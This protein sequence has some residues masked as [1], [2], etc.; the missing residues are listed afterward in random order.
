[1]SGYLGDSRLRHRI[2]FKRDTFMLCVYCGNIAETREHSP[3]KVFLSTPYPDNL[4]VVPACFDC[5]NGFS[6]DELYVSIVL[7]LLKNHFMP[8]HVLSSKILERLDNNEGVK[9]KRFVENYL[10]NPGSVLNNLTI[11]RI[12]H[13]LAICHATYEV[14]EG[15]YGSSWES[16]VQ[17]VKYNCNRQIARH[18]S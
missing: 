8:E 5:N 10:R 12:L 9:A 11:K 13:K 4:P 2:V 15:Y 1:M 3:S 7:E 18:L 17:D 14:S 16:S 6:S